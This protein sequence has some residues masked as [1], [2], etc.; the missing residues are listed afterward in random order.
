MEI[1]IRSLVVG[2]TVEE[3]FKINLSFI[4]TNPIKINYINNQATK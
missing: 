4:K 1:K 3:N 2:K